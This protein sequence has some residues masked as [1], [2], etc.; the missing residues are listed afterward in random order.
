MQIPDPPMQ[1]QVTPEPPQSP[2][3]LFL[4]DL[5]VVEFLEPTLTDDSSIDQIMSSYLE[6]ARNKGV[7]YLRLIPKNPR[8]YSSRRRV[9]EMVDVVGRLGNALRRQRPF[10]HGGSGLWKCAALSRKGFSQWDD[11]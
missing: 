9:H 11:I 3:Q 8:L 1:I 5:P 4:S 2:V 7:K 10:A 6:T